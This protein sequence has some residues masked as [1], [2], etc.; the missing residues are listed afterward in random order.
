M[1]LNYSYPEAHN[2]NNKCALYGHTLCFL[3][4]VNAV[5]QKEG[6]WFEVETILYLLCIYVLT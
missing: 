4:E 3:L 6:N 1:K 2:Y 5:L